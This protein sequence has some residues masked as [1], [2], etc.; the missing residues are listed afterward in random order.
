MASSTGIKVFS[1]FSLKRTCPF[2]LSD[3]NKA[4]GLEIRFKVKGRSIPKGTKEKTFALSLQ[5][6][7]VNFKQYLV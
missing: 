1:K 6:V 5:K 2:Y 4:L 3:D 7:S